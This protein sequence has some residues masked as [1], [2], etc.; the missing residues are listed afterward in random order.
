MTTF[1]HRHRF[2]LLLLLA[3]AGLGAWLWQAWPGLRFELARLQLGFQRELGQL[4]RH[5]QDWQ[6]GTVLALLGLSFGYGVCHAAGPGHGKLVLGT[7]LATHPSRLGQAIRLSVGAALLQ[8]LVAIGLIGLGGWLLDLSARQA[9]G[10]GVSLEKGSYL[11]VM[12]LGGW[13]AWRALRSLWQM[14]PVTPPAIRGVRPLQHQGEL[15][16]RPH[17]QASCGCGHQH[18]PDAGQL[19]AATRWQTRLGLLLAMGLRPCSG[20]LLLLVLAK[21]LQQFWLGALATL[22]MAAGTALT[23][24]VLALLSRQARQLALSLSRGSRQAERLLPKLG[25]GL[26]LL[27]GVVLIVAG[28]GLYLAPTSQLLPR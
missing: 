27:G 1:I 14:R 6:P 9:Q 16:L 10:V 18:V 13:I 17:P 7:Y 22:A 12:G 5:A 3:L 19:A 8:A 4:L 24:S 23:V 20:A 11:L 25:Q 26:A 28:L 21:V 15:L 2:R